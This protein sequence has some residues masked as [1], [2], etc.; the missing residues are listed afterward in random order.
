MN[1]EPMSIEDLV[2][3]RYR[4]Q[5]VADAVLEHIDEIGT[6][7]DIVEG[8]KTLPSEYDA[9]LWFERTRR[10]REDKRRRANG[11]PQQ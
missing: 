1:G 8:R 10:E 3:Q 5:E 6:A 4:N 11:G 7:E 2:H 9:T